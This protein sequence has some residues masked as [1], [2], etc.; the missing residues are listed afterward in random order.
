MMGGFWA[1]RL[2]V[3]SRSQ[4][5]TAAGGE[6]D[7]EQ[8]TKMCASLEGKSYAEICAAGSEKLKDCPGF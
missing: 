7:D 6:A 2:R 8:L 1:G 4:V 3:L 5:I